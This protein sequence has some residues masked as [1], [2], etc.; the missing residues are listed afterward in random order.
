MGSALNLPYFIL[1]SFLLCPHPAP[2]FSASLSQPSP[3]KI[4][5]PG[6]VR[7]AA[8]WELGPASLACPGTEQGCGHCPAFSQKCVPHALVTAAR[9]DSLHM[10]NFLCPPPRSS[11]LDAYACQVRRSANHFSNTLEP[12]FLEIH[13]HT[14]LLVIFLTCKL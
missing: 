10:K 14:N 6:K 12:S 2:P 5:V 1:C 7:E 13:V 9:P 11:D 8:V 3:Q 4:P